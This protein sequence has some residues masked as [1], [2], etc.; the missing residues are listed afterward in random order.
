MSEHAPI[1]ASLVQQETQ[2]SKKAKSAS[3]ES[4]KEQLDAKIAKARKESEAAEKAA[5]DEAK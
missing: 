1:S 2:I 3:Y 4:K 5:N